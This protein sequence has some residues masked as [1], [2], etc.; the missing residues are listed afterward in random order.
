MTTD[1]ATIPPDAVI[2]CGAATLVGKQHLGLTLAGPFLRSPESGA[3]PLVWLTRDRA[4]GELRGQYLEEGRPA[5]PSTQA[6]D[7]RLAAALRERSE[8]LT[9]Q[10]TP[11]DRVSAAPTR[12]LV[13]RPCRARHRPPPKR[14]K[15]CDWAPREQGLPVGIPTWPTGWSTSEPKVCKISNSAGGEPEESRVRHRSI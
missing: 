1:P 2:G 13:A 15:R 7:E 12:G 10:G 4:A 3:H 6:Q 8:E 9:A 5:P 11:A 14:V